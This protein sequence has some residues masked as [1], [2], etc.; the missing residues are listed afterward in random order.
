MPSAGKRLQGHRKNATDSDDG[1]DRLS[2]NAAL[3]VGT[4]L[5]STAV[6]TYYALRQPAYFYHNSAIFAGIKILKCPS[7]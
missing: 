6:I 1:Q 2:Y 3:A 4:V 7:E 5:I